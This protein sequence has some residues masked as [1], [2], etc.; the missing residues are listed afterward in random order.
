MNSK[1]ELQS[2]EMEKIS[3]GWGRET[4]NYSANFILT[5]EELKILQNAYPDLKIKQSNIQSI[6]VPEDASAYSITSKS[7]GWVDQEQL[8]DMIDAKLGGISYV[9]HDGKLFKKS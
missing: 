4:D 5:N 6:A 1:K 2:K 9:T 8:V 7:N 3:G